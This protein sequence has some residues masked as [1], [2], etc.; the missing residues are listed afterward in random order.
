MVGNKF[1]LAVLISM[2]SLS[3]ASLKNEGNGIDVVKALQQCKKIENKNDRL[4]CFDKLA[5]RFSPPKFNGR[6]NRVTEVFTLDK[7]HRLRYRSYGVIFV[8]YLRDV[9]GNVI[10]NLHLG[11]TGEDSYLI[12]TPGNYTLKIQGSDRWEIWL[13]PV[14]SLSETAE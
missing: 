12:E 9:E 13:E 5:Q 10:Q 3:N 4:T 2:S 1:L 11:G 14:D 7:P 6:L 8:L